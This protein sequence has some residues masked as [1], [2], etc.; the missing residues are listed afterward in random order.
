MVICLE[1]GADLHMAQLMSVP[2]TVSCFSKIQIGFTFLVPAHLGSP[3]QRAVKRA[4]VRVCAADG[5]G[6]VP[7]GLDDD[8]SSSQRVARL[9]ALG[10]R[11]TAAHVGRSRAAVAPAQRRRPRRHRGD[12]CR[13]RQPRAPTGLGRRGRRDA[14]SGQRTTA[15]DV[16][17]HRT[18]NSKCIGGVANSRI[19]LSAVSGV[20]QTMEIEEIIQTTGRYAAATT[21]PEPNVFFVIFHFLTF[22]YFSP[23]AK[24]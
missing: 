7:S 12:H 6:G 4:C 22:F 10:Q 2:L 11:A 1:R 17:R 24:L 14:A 13:E 3:G 21:N 18:L 20:H 9:P 15:P 23:N 16:E 8:Q 19:G 5:G